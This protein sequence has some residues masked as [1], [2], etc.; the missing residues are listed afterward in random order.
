MPTQRQMRVNSLLQEEISLI[1]L[2]ELP[3]PELNLTTITSVEVS[4]DLRHARVFA[5]VFGEDEEYRLALNALKRHRK[6]IQELIGDRL[7]LRFTP[8]LNFVADRT[9]EQA[10]R[11]ETLL[12][13]IAEEPP[14]PEAPPE[15]LPADEPDDEDEE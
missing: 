12:H 6:E 3:D 10:Q 14:L 1:V 5:S 9:A 7:D 2:R 11:I 15:S 8:R 4:P 13:R